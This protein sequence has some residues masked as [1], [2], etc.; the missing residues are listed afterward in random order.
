MLR[1][2]ATRPDRRPRLPN[3]LRRAIDRQRAEL[4]ARTPLPATG[5]AGT[6]EPAGT[7]TPLPLDAL[8]GPDQP[9][10]ASVRAVIGVTALAGLAAHGGEPLELLQRA[11][12]ALAPGGR[13]LLV[14]PYRR[15]RSAGRLA[16]LLAPPLARLTGLRPNLPVPHLVRQAGFTIASVERVTMPTLLA[17]LRSFCLIVAEAAR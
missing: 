13:L 11:R 17:P 3:R 15:S 10:A 5:P 7:V 4:L 6:H 16:D 1:P 2:P 14:E 12:V 9:P 8:L